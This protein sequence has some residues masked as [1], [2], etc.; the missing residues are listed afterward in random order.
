MQ[1]FR[2]LFKYLR[3]VLWFRPML[4][5]IGAAVALV[6]AW[7]VDQIVPDLRIEGLS[8]ATIEKLLSII[9][10]SMLAVATL[11]VGS[12][13]AAYAS[14]SST[15]TPRSF[16]LV[17]ADDGSQMA[18]SS[19]IGA[20]IFA[21]MATI[22]LLTGAY[23][24]GGLVALFTMTVGIFGWVIVT[25]LRWVDGI[26]RLGRV[27]NTIDRVEA[28]ARKALCARRATPHLGGLPI[29]DDFKGR[30]ILGTEFGY[31]QH[32]DME[33]LQACARELGLRVAVMAMPGAFVA[34]GRVVLSVTGPELSERDTARL[35]AGMQIGQDRSFEDDPRFGLVVL[36]EIAARALSSAVND[37][38][39]A[40]VIIGRFVR[41]MAD[42]AD[43]ITP[44]PPSFDRIMVPALDSQDLFEDA[45]GPIA[46]DGAAILEVGMRFQKAMI[47]LA[48]VGFVAE[49]RQQSERAMR[50][51]RAAL[52]LT[53]DADRL[54]AL[55]ETV[56]RVP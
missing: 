29:P 8:A 16:A 5:C 11:A 43:A 30:E 19:F 14:A 52:A 48:H 4:Y 44:K 2:S 54:E 33:A 1:R 50:H 56:G 27:G 41:L 20:F 42:W 22:A 10:S 9:T 18:L 26:A 17:I 15:A 23:G 38:G 6:L 40:V 36:G 31:V 45:F 55:A 21:V 35:L 25:F 28:A 46:R 37:P 49:A 32:L 7:W 24:E 12:M 51:A 13:L 39:T 47:S 3:A 34:P 53:E